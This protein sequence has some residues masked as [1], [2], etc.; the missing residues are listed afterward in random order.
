MC[1]TAAMSANLA[2]LVLF[3]DFFFGSAFMLFQ[4]FLVEGQGLYV[5]LISLGVNVQ[6]P[7]EVVVVLESHLDAGIHFL[8][9]PNG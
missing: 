7:I 1:A 3:L 6:I 5:R 9:I 4:H 8:G 2:V